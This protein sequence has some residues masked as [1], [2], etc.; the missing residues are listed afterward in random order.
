[1]E[2][3]QLLGQSFS[4][5]NRDVSSQRL[6]NMYLEESKVAGEQQWSAMPMPGA[7]L[8]TGLGGTN[9][10]ALLTHL[11][12]VYAVGDG[13][14]YSITSA[15]VATS[16]GTI[17]N[18]TELPRISM[19]AILDEILVTDSLN[20]YRYKISTDNWAEVTDVDLEDDPEIVMSL[21]G[22]FIAIIPNTQKFYVSDLNDGTS[23]NAL[24]FASAETDPD[25]LVSGFTL[26]TRMWLLGETTSEIWYNSSNPSGA[27]F[28]RAV[29][30]A[31]QV[32]CAAK[33]SVATSGN[34]AFW[35]GQNKQGLLGVIA[36]SE[37]D[38]RVISTRALNAAIQ[39]YDTISDAIGFTHQYGSHV[40]YCITFPSATASRGYTWVYDLSTDQWSEWE[41]LDEEGVTTP[42]YNR[43]LANCSCSINNKTLVGDWQSGNIY[44]LSHRVYTERGNNIKR[45]IVTPHVQMGRDRLN[46]GALE[47]KFEAGAIEDSEDSSLDEPTIMLEISK[48]LG[49][50]YGS[51]LS[52]TIGAAGEYLKRTIFRRL[53][54][55]R[56]YTFRL[57]MTDPVPWK[58]TGMW[59]NIVRR[60]R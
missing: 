24:F 51:V 31:L 6:I 20:T 18:S 14:F 8:W 3:I 12:V 32:G 36:A 58:I 59:A 19:A 17:T 47:I 48:D 56:S 2:A 33:Y 43:Y 42:F 41:S 22:Y 45:Q 40:F 1:M 9:V 55:A 28:D 49:K 57:T 15:G 7:T 4:P 54:N 11:G 39:H 46:I 13:T 35:L 10:R 44:E 23:W 29:A 5:E 26:N 60:G 38:F 34:M 37:G 30:G 21:N 53:G 52:R 16:Q 25:K 50:S 27:P